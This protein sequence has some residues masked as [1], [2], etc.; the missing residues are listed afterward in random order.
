MGVEFNVLVGTVIEVLDNKVEI[1]EEVGKCPLCVTPCNTP[2]CPSC[3]ARIE[4]TLEKDVQPFFLAV[5]LEDL[6]ESD[7]D[8]F[9]VEEGMY[10]RINQVSCVGR[11]FYYHEDACVRVNRCSD[12]PQKIPEHNAEPYE[13][14]MELFTQRGVNFQMVHGI[15][16]C[17]S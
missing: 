12:L 5:W 10:V 2:Y 8:L 16:G 14:L 11:C 13:P 6:W 15:F 4:L 3:G 7:A 17:W 1:S 9:G